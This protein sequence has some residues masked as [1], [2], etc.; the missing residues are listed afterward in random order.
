MKHWT[1][2]DNDKSRN[3]ELRR[4]EIQQKAEET[5]LLRQLVLQNTQMVQ[6]MLQ[7]KN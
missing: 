4:Q 2:Y 6:S 5:E 3:F 7:N 1:I